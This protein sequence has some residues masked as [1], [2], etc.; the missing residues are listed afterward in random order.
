MPSTTLWLYV[1]FR[2]DSGCLLI[3]GSKFNEALFDA[4]RIRSARVSG[5]TRRGWLWETSRVF[6]NFF[7]YK[8]VKNWSWDST[9]NT[10]QRIVSR[11]WKSSASACFSPL[12]SFVHRYGCCPFHDSVRVVVVDKSRWFQGAFFVMHQSPWRD[13]QRLTDDVKGVKG[14]SSNVKTQ[15][16]RDSLIQLEGQKTSKPLTWPASK[17]ISDVWKQI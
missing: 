14:M 15:R 16:F 4:P 2:D 8:V 12:A 9:H 11:R 1:L 17:P 10:Q 3:G 7:N 6:P 5:N 13:K